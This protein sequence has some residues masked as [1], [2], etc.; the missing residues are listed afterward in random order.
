MLGCQTSSLSSDSIVKEGRL[1]VSPLACRH[2]SCVPIS[3]LPF[4]FFFL[5]WQQTVRHTTHSPHSTPPPPTPLLK[6]SI[7]LCPA[8]THIQG[9][10]SGRPAFYYFQS[11]SDNQDFCFEIDHF[12]P[13]FYSCMSGCAFCSGTA[14]HNLQ[15]DLRDHQVRAVFLS[16]FFVF[17]PSSHEPFLLP[18]FG[19]RPMMASDA[20][21][22]KEQS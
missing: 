20:E 19:G 7:K 14:Q 6:K 4:F 17:L 2:P 15:D 5:A 21:L 10:P 12:F 22:I 18:D 1:T 8:L 13:F 16:F 9:R 3:T 11:K